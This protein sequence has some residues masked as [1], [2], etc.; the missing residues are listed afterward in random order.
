MKLP[1]TGIR[2]FLALV[3][4]AVLSPT[5]P[6][7]ADPPPYPRM[8]VKNNTP[9]TV[10]GKFVCSYKALDFNMTA[11]DVIMDNLTLGPNGGYAERS[12]PDK[13][14]HTITSQPQIDYGGPTSL[15][16]NGT[17][18]CFRPPQY[19]GGCVTGVVSLQT[20]GGWYD[21]WSGYNGKFIRI[22]LEVGHW[23]VSKQDFCD[24]TI[25]WW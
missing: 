16:V 25:G 22:D 4:V 11:K 6:A 13:V 12:F 18:L 8:S 9:F 21:S 15:T 1:S 14:A 3:V 23:D 24:I 20:P 10:V 5:S 2:Y 19:G 17:G 7:F